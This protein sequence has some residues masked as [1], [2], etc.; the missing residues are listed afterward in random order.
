MNQKLMIVV[1][2][3]PQAGSNICSYY[4]NLYSKYMSKCCC[5]CLLCNQSQ[6]KEDLACLSQR[7]S[8]WSVNVTLKQKLVTNKKICCHK[9]KKL[10]NPRPTILCSSSFINTR[11]AKE[12]VK[13]PKP[14]PLS[15]TRQKSIIY[16]AKNSRG[17]CKN[18][19]KADVKDIFGDLCDGILSDLERRPRNHCTDKTSAKNPFSH[20]KPS[21]IAS[22]AIKPK[23]N[24]PICP[25]SSPCKKACSSY[26]SKD[27][28]INRTKIEK[29]FNNKKLPC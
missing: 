3:F 10:I 26:V 12:L 15:D 14:R 2:L 16:S 22:G 21:K 20:K 17:R 24:C 9:T 13:V 11:K 27:R 7:C 5:Q 6:Q 19:V 28:V 4:K 29:V 18:V 23:N 1:K 25:C 8:K